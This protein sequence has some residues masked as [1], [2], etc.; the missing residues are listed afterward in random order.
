MNIEDLKGLMDDFDPA[1]LLPEMDGLLEGIASVAR[2]AV[3]VGP[4]LLLIAGLYAM[5]GLFG[6]MTRLCSGWFAGFRESLRQ[7]YIGALIPR[8]EPLRIGRWGQLQEWTEDL[9]DPDDHHRHVSHLYALY[10]SSQITVNTPELM[11]AAR[12]SLEHRGDD[13]TGWGMGWRVA[14][15]ARL[16]DGERAYDVLRRQLTPT[17]ASLGG[18]YRGGT[19]DNLFDSHPPFQIDGNFGCT[20]GIAEL[21][22]Q[23]HEKTPDGKVVIRLLPALP[24]AWPDGSVKGFRARGGYVVDFEWKAGKL[25]GKTV[26][27]GR[28]G[29]YIIKEGWG[30]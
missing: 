5:A 1:V 26:A 29:G 11:K 18:S 28:E 30:K 17:S 13:A 22:L 24:K 15:W 3:L 6:R 8:L 19:Y 7:S 2:I 12:V 23:S 21:L 27:G 20:A 25:T 16:G 14:L 9:D 4:V 10:P